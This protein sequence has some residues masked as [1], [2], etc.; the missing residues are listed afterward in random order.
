MAVEELLGVVRLGGDVSSLAQ[1][2]HGLLRRGPVAPRARDEE[3]LVV[4]DRLAVLQRFL[5]G[6]REPAHVLAVQGSHRRYRAGVAH[7]V[8]PALL[9]FR[10]GDYDLVRELAQRAL[11]L[12][13]HQPDGAAEGPRALEA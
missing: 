8:A 3:P 1:L 11:G 5:D 7:R 6:V 4:A 10:S 2:E 13:G 9:D 12:P